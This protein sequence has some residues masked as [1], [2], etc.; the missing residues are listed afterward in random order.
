MIAIQ[1]T[2]IKCLLAINQLYNPLIVSVCLVGLK[3]YLQAQASHSYS[4]GMDYFLVCNI[5]SNIINLAFLVR[6]KLVFTNYMINEIILF[7]IQQ[8]VVVHLI[9]ENF[10]YDINVFVVLNLFQLCCSIWINLISVYDFSNRAQEGEHGRSDEKLDI[11]THKH[12]TVTSLL[13]TLNNNY[14]P[15]MLTNSFALISFSEL[16][17]DAHIAS[18]YKVLIISLKFY[19][20]VQYILIELWDN[21]V[22]G[23]VSLSDEMPTLNLNSNRYLVVACLLI[24]GIDIG[25][26]FQGR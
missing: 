6:Y 26:L 24:I 12:T 15:I 13:I 5:I 1:R 17:V 2:L 19:C 14:L 21:E 23:K 4:E 18:A 7:V 10:V 11:T 16:S 22:L 25:L 9:Y 3:V 20:L 8:I